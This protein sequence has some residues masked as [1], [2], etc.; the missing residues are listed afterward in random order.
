MSTAVQ[1]LTNGIIKW[2]TVVTAGAATLGFCA[3]LDSADN[4]VN[5]LG[6]GEDLCIGMF[7]ATAVAGARVPVLIPNPIVRVVVGTNG[8]T[9][10]KKAIPVATGL[11][12][13]PTH[14]SDGTSNSAIVGIFMQS[15]TVGQRVGMQLTISSRGS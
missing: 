5:N 13:A 11:E 3:K 12:D 14:D 10:S 1:D 2:Y 4:T 9:R 8:A 15:G 6:A 7:L